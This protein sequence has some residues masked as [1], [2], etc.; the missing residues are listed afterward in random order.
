[1]EGRQQKF[2]APVVKRR[3]G[4]F[5]AFAGHAPMRDDDADVGDDAADFRPPF[6]QG[7]RSSDIRRKSARRGGASRRIAS[8]R[9]A[10]VPGEDEGSHRETV[11]GRRRDQAQAAHARERHLQR[12]GDRRGAERE[13]VDIGLERLETLLLGDAE[14]LLLVDDEQSEVGETH[15]FAKQR[16]GADGDIDRPVG[17]PGAHG[18]GALA[19]HQA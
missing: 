11:D 3:H 2:V 16:V 1:M 12:A 10:G 5:E 19:G 18:V 9:V 4:F 8:R 14:T 7:P 17:D 15:R 13:D 6:P